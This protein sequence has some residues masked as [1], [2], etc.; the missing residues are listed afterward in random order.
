MNSVFLAMV[1]FAFV[2]AVTPG[3]VNLL[4]TS[5]AVNQGLREA[6]KH[7]VAASFAYALVV[8]LCGGVMQSL[9]ALIPSLETTMQ[10]LGSAFLLYLAYKI[11]T[12]PVSK[13]EKG[14]QAKSG[15]LTGSVTQLLNPKAWLYALSGVSIYV[16]GKEDES[17]WLVIYTVVSLLVCLFSI[18]L[19]AVLGHIL[20]SKLE[21]PAKQRQF[22][23]F[24]A[25]VLALSVAIIWI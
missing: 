14:Q 2:G 21:N 18:G 4:A 22:N 8:V 6:I 19:W 3:P 25:T 16:I 11:F 13:F 12:A 17:G 15:W 5:T 23:R 20:S 9:L 10:V 1:T 24:M 7:V